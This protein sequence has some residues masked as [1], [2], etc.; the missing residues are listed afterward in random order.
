MIRPFTALLVVAL[1]TIHAV[2]VEGMF[3]GAL[4]AGEHGIQ[5]QAVSPWN[6]PTGY[7]PVV[8]T[9]DATREIDL[10]LRIAG[11]SGSAHATVRV[12]AGR[13]ARQTILLPPSNSDST[14]YQNLEWSGPGGISGSTQIS[15]F[16]H[17]QIRC[18][19][20]DPKQQVIEVDL[21]SALGKLVSSGG[22]SR[23]DLVLRIQPQDL[24]DRWQGYP[25]WLVLVLT[26]PGDAVLEEAQR[27]AIATWTRSGGTL[28]VT[29]AELE[30]TWSAQQAAVLL[31][32]LL[33]VPTVL[34]DELNQQISRDGWQPFDA[35]VPGTETVPVKTFVVLALAFAIV[36]GPLNLWW[37]R[38]RNARH[39][40]LI[41][42]PLLSFATCVVLII[43]SLV[44]DGISVKR[45]A[46]QVCY[47]DHRT[48]QAIRWTGCTYFAAFARSQVE[49]D[50][51]TKLRVLDRADYAA[52]SR[53]SRG[54]GEQ[55]HLDWRRGQVLSGTVLPARLNRQLSYTE[56][57][58]ERRRLVVS[59][60]G[61]GYQVV[62]GLGV[63]LQSVAWRDASGKLWRADA[64]A[65]GESAALAASSDADGQASA[66]A[67]L[68][69]SAGQTLPNDVAN[70]LGREVAPL[71]GRV[72]AEPLTFSAVLA[73]PMDSLPGPS[74][75]DPQ[76]PRV[77]AFG[78]L[79][80]AV[81]NV[82]G[83]P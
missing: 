31:D 46:V 37:V 11:D 36:V 22:S 43:A 50:A 2:R 59:R 13:A 21:E 47:L 78:H 49:L 3:A 58:P 62:N 14:R 55:L 18:A 12:S 35:P 1:L 45:D 27:Q 7:T 54:D 10:D 51:Q 17:Q 42:T 6:D 25:D 80:L 32:P 30:R 60:Q 76:P 20:I 64:I 81:A 29:T 61:D 24:P 19:L 72:T 75:S 82:E 73:A 52:R 41:T 65:V 39:L 69:L 56:H 28:V 15:G 74:A 8:V 23:R 53:R 57:L 33:N 63:A 34:G 83:A 70:R 4:F 68:P 9:V 77:I 44:A 71:F 38:K 79:P 40:F 5:M 16:N 66:G 26:P 67:K 48:Q